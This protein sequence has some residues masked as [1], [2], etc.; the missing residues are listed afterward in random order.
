MRN[1]PGSL[2]WAGIRKQMK[3]FVKKYKIF[4]PQC[5][6][7]L[8]PVVLRVKDKERKKQKYFGAWFRTGWL[9]KKR[10]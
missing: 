10:R 7:P 3:Q 8:F 4:L 2:L 5:N 9:N 6:I 1:A